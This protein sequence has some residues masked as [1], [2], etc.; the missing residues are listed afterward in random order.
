MNALLWVA[1]GGSII[2]ETATNRITE[3][4]TPHAEAHADLAASSDLTVGPYVCPLPLVE[5]NAKRGLVPGVPVSVI[6][7][8]RLA[9][10][11]RPQS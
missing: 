7:C 1:G 5:P 3:A 2:S 10:C 8:Y 11:L 6:T 4:Y 9:N